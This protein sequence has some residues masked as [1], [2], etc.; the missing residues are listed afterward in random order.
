MAEAILKGKIKNED[1]LNESFTAW[2]AG[3]YAHQGDP[4][5]LYS[6]DV[7]RDKWG[8]DI[9]GHRARQLTEDDIKK[10]DLILTMTVSHKNTVV[11]LFPD[12]RRK[13]FTL[14]EYLSD[15]CGEP[16]NKTIDISDPFGGNIKVYQAC[17]DELKELMDL[18]VKKLNSNFL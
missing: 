5:S 4:A 6:R 12:A 7:L 17:A 1:N 16:D 3:I 14:K 13:T 2:S 8:L 10:A 11:S 18:L 9:S 15:V